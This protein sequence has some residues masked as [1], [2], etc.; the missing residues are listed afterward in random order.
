MSEIQAKRF[1]QKDFHR[2]SLSIY[3]NH[4]IADDFIDF[5]FYLLATWGCNYTLN[6]TNVILK[7]RQN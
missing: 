2:F 3:K 7:G 6:Y 4:L 5:D 1:P